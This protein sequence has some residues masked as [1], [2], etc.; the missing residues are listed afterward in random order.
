LSVNIVLNII[1]PSVIAIFK[2]TLARSSRGENA[3]ASDLLV[4]AGSGASA[5]RGEE[6]VGRQH[7]HD[8]LTVQDREEAH[9]LLAHPRGRDGQERVGRDGV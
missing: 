5:E 4:P 1:S 9:S 7:T 2:N 3:S 6:V 8:A